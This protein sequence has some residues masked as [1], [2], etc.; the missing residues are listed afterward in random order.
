MVVPVAAAQLVTRGFGTT[1]ALSMALGLASGVAG[2]VISGPS[3]TAPGATV[4]LVAI[5]L[6]LVVAIGSAG[7]R[8]WRRRSMPTAPAAIDPPDVLLGVDR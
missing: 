6:F 8:T 3:D 5:G 4:V 7:L 1:M 2:I